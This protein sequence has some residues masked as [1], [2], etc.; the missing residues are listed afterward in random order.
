MQIKLRRQDISEAKLHGP[1]QFSK[2]KYSSDLLTEIGDRPAVVSVHSSHH[3]M[4]YN[5]PLLLPDDTVYS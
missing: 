5:C 1:V 3:K 4:A 2:F